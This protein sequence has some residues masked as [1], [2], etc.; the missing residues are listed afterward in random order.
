MAYESL[1]TTA[2]TT[3]PYLG[4][5]PVEVGVVKSYDIGKALSEQHV[6]LS[7]VTEFQ[8]YV[9]FTGLPNPELKPSAEVKR[10]VYELYTEPTSQ[11]YRN[12]KY[13]NVVFDQKDTVINSANL[14]FPYINGNLYAHIPKEWTTGARLPD[15]MHKAS[16][17]AADCQHKNIHEV[18]QAYANGSRVVFL[19]LFLTGYRLKSQ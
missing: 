8:I 17:T 11:L 15:H 5:L 3:P 1:I 19:D 16:R 9:F 12:S 10:G 2:V 18:M 7:Q 14:W 4:T 13:M 6:D